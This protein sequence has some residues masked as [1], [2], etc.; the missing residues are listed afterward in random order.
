MTLAARRMA[1]FALKRRFD[2]QLSRDKR[3][4]GASLALRTSL[5]RRFPV[6]SGTNAS[7]D[8]ALTIKQQTTM[9]KEEV[10]DHSAAPWAV[11]IF[12]APTIVLHAALNAFPLSNPP[13]RGLFHIRTHLRQRVCPVVAMKPCGHRPRQSVATASRNFAGMESLFCR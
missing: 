11:P 7:C 9:P 12:P 1:G 10:S 3:L 13:Q 6:E 2:L 5:R 4:L 8:V